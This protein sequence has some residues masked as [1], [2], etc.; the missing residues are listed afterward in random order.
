MCVASWPRFAQGCSQA[1]PAPTQ[2]PF[3]EINVK[4]NRYLER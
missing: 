2:K 1:L 4:Q 3:G